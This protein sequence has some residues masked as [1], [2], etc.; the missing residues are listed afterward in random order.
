MKKLNEQNVHEILHDNAIA[1]D[2][3][4]SYDPRKKTIQSFS[5][6]IEDKIKLDTICRANA[7]DASK[8]LRGCVKA[9]IEDYE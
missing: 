9:L 5:I 8:F 4:K 1:F 6:P 2:A 3:E 7:S